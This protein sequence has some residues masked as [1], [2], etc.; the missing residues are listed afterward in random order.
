M[1]VFEPT[2]SGSEKRGLAGVPSCE[3]LVSIGAASAALEHPT[4]VPDGQ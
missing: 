3:Q 4:A 1:A 2:S